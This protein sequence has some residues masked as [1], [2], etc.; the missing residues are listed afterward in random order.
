MQMQAYIRLLY[1]VTEVEFSFDSFS[2]EHVP[3]DIKEFIENKNTIANIF[4]VQANNSV[5]CGYF[6]IGF[7][8][9]I[10]A[11]IKQ[12]DFTNMISPHDF[13]KNGDIIYFKGQ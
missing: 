6:C 10:L 1:F 3:E 7:I 8:D 11:G 5:L 13:K 9:F 2:A 12:T 4:Q